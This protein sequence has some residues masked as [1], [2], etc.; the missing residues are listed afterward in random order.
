MGPESWRSHPPRSAV[1]ARQPRAILSTQLRLTTSVCPPPSG[2]QHPPPAPTR[3]CTAASTGPLPPRRRPTRPS[4]QARVPGRCPP[5]PPHLR[6]RRASR[7]LLSARMPQRPPFVFI[8]GEAGPAPAPAPSRCPEGGPWA[9]ASWRG[10]AEEPVRGPK[11][12]KRSGGK[13]RV[14][15]GLA[16]N[17]RGY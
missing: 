5:Q 10:G 4:N 17:G 7:D 9:G 14:W 12:G 1:R 15:A 6:H 16:P 11:S 2:P 13:R 3:A 8:P